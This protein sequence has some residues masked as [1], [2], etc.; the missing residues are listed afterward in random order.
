MPYEEGLAGY[1]LGRHLPFHD[2][3]RRRYLERACAHFEQTRAFRDLARARAQM[4]RG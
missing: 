4:G 3:G 2:P 1:E